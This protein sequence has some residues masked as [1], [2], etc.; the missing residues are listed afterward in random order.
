VADHYFT[1]AE[2]NAA[3]TELRPVVERMVDLRRH[4]R[5]AIDSRD[6]LAARIGSNGGGISASDVAGLDTQIVELAG[7]LEAC[8]DRLHEAGVQVKDLDTGLIDFPSL[9]D[10]AEVLLCWRAGEGEIEYW[11]GLDEGFAGRKPVDPVE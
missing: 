9:R 8:I 6:D 2:A 10:G 5:E 7:A 3:L 1:L 11:H 4:H